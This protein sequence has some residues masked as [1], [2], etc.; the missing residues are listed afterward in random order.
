M[1]VIN[2]GEGKYMDGIGMF[3]EPRSVALVGATESGGTVGCTLLENLLSAKNERKIYPVNPS[4]ETIFDVKCYPDISALPEVPDLTIIA[5]N[6]KTV[7]DIVE[8]AGKAGS[9]NI[10]IISSGF[11]ETGKE[12]KS[13]NLTVAP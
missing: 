13:K 8:E 1:S 9:K 10:I 11:K 7:P 12:G 6:A 3:F 5:T 4:R 2:A